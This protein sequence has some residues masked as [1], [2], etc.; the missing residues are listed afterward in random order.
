MLLN[1]LVQI[2]LLLVAVA[3]VVTAAGYC[4]RLSCERS[5]L[6]LDISLL[7]LDC[8][9]AGASKNQP[10]QGFHQRILFAVMSKKPG[11]G[12]GFSGQV[13]ARLP[14]AVFHLLAG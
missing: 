8:K 7:K 6:N 10:R 1:Y 2:A 11:K 4:S 12:S 9:P 13:V 3:V 5:H 14:Y